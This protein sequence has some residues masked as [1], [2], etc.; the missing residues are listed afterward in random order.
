MS[1]A[2]RHGAWLVLAFALALFACSDDD[3]DGDGALAT[4]SV[5]A[6]LDA[7]SELSRLIVPLEA[8]PD[9]GG[10]VPDVAR[11]LKIQ[12]AISSFRALVA[13]PACV[14]VA[15]DNLTSLDVTFDRCRI[16]L[17]LALD[18]SLH[19]GIAIEAAG[20]L[21]SRL[22]VSVTIPSLVLAGPLRSRRLS[23]A[24]ELRQA[25]PPL[26]A[27]VELSGELGFE[28]DGGAER[29]LAFGAESAVTGT[30]VSFTGGGQ[31]SG[32]MLGELGPIALSGQKIRGCRDQCPTAGSVELSYGRG[33]LLSWTYTGA[34]TASVIGPRGKRVEVPLGCGGEGG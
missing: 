6:A 13:N 9:L 2:D 18:G 29:R 33:T 10:L 8:S 12:N 3:G 28:V 25:I 15:T 21:A 16:A 20:G 11:A 22:V 7:S 32:E 4:D 34:D 30:C 5:A 1:A 23:G 14:K 24:L 19:A 26:G 31:L 27:P 17:V